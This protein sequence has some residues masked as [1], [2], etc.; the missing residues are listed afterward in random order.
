MKRKL[1]II[2]MALGLCTFAEAADR[3]EK[4]LSTFNSLKNNSSTPL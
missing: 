3:K 1:T 2:M 4:L